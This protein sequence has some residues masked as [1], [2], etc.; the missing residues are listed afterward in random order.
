MWQQLVYAMAKNL[1]HLR[2]MFWRNVF[3]CFLRSE[4]TA[5]ARPRAGSCGGTRAGGLLRKLSKHG[6]P[7]GTYIC[8]LSSQAHYSQEPKGGRTQVFTGRWMDKQNVEYIHE[9]WLLSL[10]KEGDSST[11]SSVENP[12]DTMLSEASQLQQGKF[13]TLSLLWGLQRCRRLPASMGRKRK[14]ELLFHGYRVS[15]WQDE[16][17]RRRRKGRAVQ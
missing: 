4:F 13:C 12:E 14:G 7:Y 3:Q 10:T 11:C 2:A 8:V 1:S 16:Q 9:G 17:F 15:V 5:G 6:N